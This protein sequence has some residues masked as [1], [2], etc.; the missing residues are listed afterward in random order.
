M[1]NILM[2]PSPVLWICRLIPLALWGWFASGVVAEL[3]GTLVWPDSSLFMAVLI[4]LLFIDF[5]LVYGLLP[6]LLYEGEY[7]G[8]SKRVNYCVFAS[9]T[10]GIGPTIWYYIK[11]DP[12]LRKMAAVNK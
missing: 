11:V 7:R 12:V 3:F 9:M 5:L 10:A 4:S 6:V 2:Q 8:L 1:K